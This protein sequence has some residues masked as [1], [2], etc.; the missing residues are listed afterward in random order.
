MVVG[1]LLALGAAIAFGVTIPFVKH[2]GRAVG[3]FATAFFLYAGAAVGTLRR[4]SPERSVLEPRHLPRLLAVA[5]FGAFL[6][7]VCLSWGLARAPAAP[8]ALAMNFEA[9]FTLALAAVLY[10]EPIGK[11][12]L[13]AAASIFVA[14]GL[15]VAGSVHGHDGSP[16]GMLAVVLATFAWALDN[17]LTRPLAELDPAAVV[18]AKG[19]MGATL[20]LAMAW[21]MG[22]LPVPRTAAAGLLACGLTGYG[23]SLRMYLLAQRKIGAAR[24]GSIFALGPFVGAGLAL[25]WGDRTGGPILY[26]AAALFAIGAYLH[27]SEQHEHAHSHEAATHEHPHT[28]DDDHHTHEHDPPFRGEHTHPH[29]HEERSHAHPHAPDVHHRHRHRG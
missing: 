7:P 18:R 22:E 12:V 13:L 26:V 9:T 19:V 14:G 5:V 29:H 27:L 23:M 15:L 6:A 11:R 25:L 1:G 3:P 16:W 20:S 2:F 8:A 21:T 17:T 28:H 24:T 10:A 4:P